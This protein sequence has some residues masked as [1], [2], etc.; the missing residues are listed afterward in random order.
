ML[1]YEDISLKSQKN[2]I[3]DCI[4]PKI[5]VYFPIL[6]VLRFTQD[7]DSLNLIFKPTEAISSG[8]FFA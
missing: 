7:Q 3:Y 1:I 2:T 4:V 6:V 5:G 8:Y